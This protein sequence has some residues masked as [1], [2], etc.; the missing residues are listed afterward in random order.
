[1]SD[2]EKQVARQ[3]GNTHSEIYKTADTKIS[4]DL[5]EESGTRSA[6]EIK[7]GNVYIKEYKES[8]HR[9]YKK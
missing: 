8:F 3:S 6:A 9:I 1:M 2:R 4:R 5:Y 7:Q